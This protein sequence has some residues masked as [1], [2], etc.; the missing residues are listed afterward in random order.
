[1]LT[2]SNRRFFVVTSWDDYFLTFSL[3]ARPRT[4]LRLDRPRAD[5]TDNL[6]AF[7]SVGRTYPLGL[8]GCASLTSQPIRSAVRD[9]STV[10]FCCVF[11]VS[12]NPLM[13]SGNG[14]ASSGFRFNISRV[15]HNEIVEPNGANLNSECSFPLKTK[16]CSRSRAVFLFIKLIPSNL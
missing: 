6:M 3:L 12:F 10:R 13:K 8:I 9:D 7:A 5:L 11:V 4:G 16:R 15:P 1:M 2:R 14:I